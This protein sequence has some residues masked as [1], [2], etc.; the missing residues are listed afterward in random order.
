VLLGSFAAVALSLA[1]VGV[2]GLVSFSTR[3]RTHE[4]GVRMALGAR[5]RDVIR[6][7]LDECWMLVGIGVVLGVGTALA[8][9]RLIRQVLFG[10]QPGDLP[11][12]AGA[13]LLIALVSTLAGYLPA[14]RAARV[15]PLRA[16]HH[17]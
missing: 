4:I 9:G 6:M 11:T 10:L 7:V 17:E 13:T 5:S 8:C 3:Q 16:L 14:R 12:M 2:Y 15:D 1:G